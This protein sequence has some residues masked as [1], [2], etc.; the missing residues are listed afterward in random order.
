MN[1]IRLIN[2]GM[3]PESF[4]VLQSA[5]AR[6]LRERG[7]E[8]QGLPVTV[9]TDPALR[10]DA[11]RA[12]A[13]GDAVQIRAGGTIG[14]FSGVGDY[15]RRCSFDGQG[16][17]RP[18]TGSF[19][20]TPVNPIHGMYF[21][22]HFWNFY[23][24]AP[25]EEIRT[26]LE[27]LALRGCNAVM[28]WYDMHQYA[29][30]DTPASLEMIARLKAVFRHASLTGMKTVF[31]TL[32]NESFS[33]SDPAVRAEW[34]VQ[35]GYYALPRGH[36]HVEI[37]PNKPGGLEEILRQR[38]RVMDAFRDIRID[39]ISIWPYDQ[40]GC[41]CGKCTPWGANGFLK[42]LD[43]LRD[44]YAEILPDAKLLCSTWYF[45]R[46]VREW[47][48]FRDAFETGKYDYVNYLFG[49]FANDEP[50]PDFIREGKMPGG[51]RMVAFPEIS[52]HS[53]SPWGGFGAN[54]MPGRL[55]EN[56]LDNGSLYC[57]AL[58]YSEGIFEDVN[59]AMMLAFYSGRLQSAD[60][61]LREYARF[62]FC[63]DGEDAEDFV[64]MVRLLE[65][66]LARRSEDAKGEPISWEESDLKWED[67]RFVIE[68]PDGAEEAERL[69]KEIDGKLPEK[70]RDGWRW[71]I[72]RLRAAIDGELVSNGMRLTENIE[73]WMKKLTEIY[74]AE[75]AYYCVTPLT[76]AA[77][78]RK[79]DGQIL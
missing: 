5:V 40:G 8:A 10:E 18:F 56:F 60:E 66:T 51:K 57:G 27:D 55:E 48:G 34:W 6:R 65:G 67:L 21:A 61:V 16:G 53:C 75:N 77:V 47:E 4:A 24:E 45:D 1:G 31:G 28:A 23:E 2:Y 13:A 64:R 46:F 73:G 69:A 30:V 49:Y 52:M 76:R 14:A 42:T 29:D 25:I 15:L 59:K 50:V 44:L 54:P 39:Y 68:H 7:C 17:F 20:F 63:L 43:A 26:L 74:H 72:L 79:T 22:S 36:Y 3:D 78:A 33:S 41:T 35:N 58:P 11:Y 9:E 70:I 19:D 12:E 71:Q 62:E 38:R 32:A 37:C